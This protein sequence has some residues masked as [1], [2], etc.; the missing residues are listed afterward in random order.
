MAQ[1]SNNRIGDSQK[2]LFATALTDYTVALA[3]GM[4]TTQSGYGDV[5][6]VGTQRVDQ[7]GN[8]YAWVKNVAL[9]AAR[10]YGP[11]CYLSAN[12][13]L[14]TFC[15]QCTCTPA[16]ADVQFNAGVWMSAVPSLGFGW[17]MINGIT[18]AK[19]AGADTGTTSAVASTPVVND[20]IAVSTL[21]T[22]TGTNVA[23]AYA[24]LANDLGATVVGT[25]NTGTITV[26]DIVAPGNATVIV[27][28][29][30]VGSGT[31]TTPITI[32]IRGFL[33]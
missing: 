15:Q 18:L 4:L 32:R 7:F 22:T 21:T 11:A 16:A 28:G 17:I 26:S 1:G 19:Y 6:G 5:E 14:Y 25:G 31:A 12:A 29:V 30:A 8:V 2:I 20:L 24:F 3:T 10:Q 23:R 13:G 9:V 27:G 33:A